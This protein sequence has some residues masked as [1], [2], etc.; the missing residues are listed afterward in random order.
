MKKIL[1]KK[2]FTLA[3]VLIVVAIIAVLVAVSFP[4]FTQQRAKSIVAANMAN[5][6]AAKA[7]AY[8][9][10]VEDSTSGVD[11]KRYAYYYYDITTGTITNSPDCY[12]DSLNGVGGA[13]AE[14]ARNIAL[15]NKVVPYIMVFVSTNDPDIIDTAPFYGEDG[16]INPYGSPYGH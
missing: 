3:E 1:N 2:G 7:T 9:K 11:I 16:T 6:R 10:L 14:E 8:S 4:I 5:I 13:E 12:T 15:Q